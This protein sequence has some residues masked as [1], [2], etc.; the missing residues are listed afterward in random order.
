MVEVRIAEDDLSVSSYGSQD[1]IG[2]LMKWQHMIEVARLVH[3]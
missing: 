2:L 1:R 3:F